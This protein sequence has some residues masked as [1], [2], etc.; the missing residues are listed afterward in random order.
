MLLGVGQIDRLHGRAFNIGGGPANTTSLLEL[1]ERIGTLRGE[2]PS[3]TFDDWRT[4]DQRYYVSDVRA[5]GAATGWIPRT[6]VAEGVERLHEWL[7]AA[8]AGAPAKV[9]AG[10]A[11]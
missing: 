11:A 6:G 4:G 3:L 2:A 7:V 9:G 10:A 1:V 8:R 5:F